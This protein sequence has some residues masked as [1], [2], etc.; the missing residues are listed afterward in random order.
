MLII[1]FASTAIHLIERSKHFAQVN[2]NK[3]DIDSSDLKITFKVLGR[4]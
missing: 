2:S 1:G 3:T 4:R